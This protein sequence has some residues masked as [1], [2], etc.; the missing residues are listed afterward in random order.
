MSSNRF[1]FLCGAA[2]GAALMYFADPQRGR[3]RRAQLRAQAT[4]LAGQAEKKARQ[5][6]NVAQGIAHDARK[7]VSAAK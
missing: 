4:S 5:L 1:L 6:S 3:R 2:T 7:T